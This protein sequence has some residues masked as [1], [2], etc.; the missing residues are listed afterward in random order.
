MYSDIYIMTCQGV[1][2]ICIFLHWLILTIFPFQQL[3]HQ[4]PLCSEQGDEEQKIVK[5]IKS[6]NIINFVGGWFCNVCHNFATTNFHGKE[7]VSYKNNYAHFSS[8]DCGYQLINKIFH[9]SVQWYTG[10]FIWFRYPTHTG[11]NCKNIKISCMDLKT[12]RA[13]L[14]LHVRD[15]GPI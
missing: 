2:P 5:C 3:T 8:I 1:T 6:C 10:I 4:Y 13:M 14:K 12:S 9:C 15:A 7:Q 11:S